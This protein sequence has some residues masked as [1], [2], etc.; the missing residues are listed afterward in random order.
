M[1]NPWIV[2]L[3][4]LKLREFESKWIQN[5]LKW[6]EQYYLI[7]CKSVWLVEKLAYASGIRDAFLNNLITLIIELEDEKT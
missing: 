5:Y 3:L 2:S 4:D 1:M 6:V 7:G